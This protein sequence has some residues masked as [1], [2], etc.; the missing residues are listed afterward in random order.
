MGMLYH[1]SPF[2]ALAVN[3]Q[4]ALSVLLELPHVT[5]GDNQ[6]TPSIAT[7][8]PGQRER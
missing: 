2:V 1:M 6:L 3:K 7:V 4:S 5:R 8:P